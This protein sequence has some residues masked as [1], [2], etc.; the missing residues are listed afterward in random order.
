MNASHDPHQGHWKGHLCLEIPPTDV[1]VYPHICVCAC[2]WVHNWSLCAAI[3]HCIIPRYFVQ[4]INHRDPWALP[5]IQIFWPWGYKKDISPDP[6]KVLERGRGA[7]RGGRKAFK[8]MKF[9][10]N[11]K[12]KTC[13]DKPEPDL[14]KKKKKIKLD[15]FSFSPLF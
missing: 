14:E 9:C 10:Y 1:V 3:S 7:E 5:W 15:F 6:F 2:V 12:E 4:C 8:V 13:G 11:L